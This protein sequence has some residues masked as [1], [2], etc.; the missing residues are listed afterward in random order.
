MIYTITFSPSIDYSLYLDNLE[1]GKINRTRK[2]IYTPGGKGINVSIV[3]SRLGVK[4]VATGFVGGFTGKY[5]EQ[6]LNSIGVANDFVEVDGVTRINVKINASEETAIN[7]NG[8]KISKDD[9]GELIEKISDCDSED[10]VVISGSL[11]KFEYKNSF[12]L[13]L[14][15]LEK[16]NT[17]IIIDTTGK[18]LLESLKYHPFLVKPNKEELEEVIGYKIKTNE[19]LLNASNKLLELGALNVIVSLG[20]DGAYM[21]GKSL[22][23]IYTRPYN[24]KAYDSVGAG[25]SL[26][27]GFIYEY[28]KTK[29]YIKALKVGVNIG[30]ATVYSIGLASDEEIKKA[31]ENV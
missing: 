14:S 30:A 12:E 8:I 9:L 25:D 31:L 10:I 2:E 21:I 26:V 22:K 20:K 15:E 24:G 18:N 29:D 7:G 28:L 1:K 11:P 23:P 16:R 5:I 19:D 13:L 17:K 3:L 6:E 27:A 4:S